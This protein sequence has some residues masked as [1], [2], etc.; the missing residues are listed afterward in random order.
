MSVN[1]WQVIGSE[2]SALTVK[3]LLNRATLNNQI[4]TKTNKR[5]SIKFSLQVKFCREKQGATCFKKNISWHVFMIFA[6][7]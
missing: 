6:A 1:V 2:L 7:Y 4:S 5:S 3:N